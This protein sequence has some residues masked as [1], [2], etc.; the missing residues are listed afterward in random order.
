MAKELR[1]P[2]RELRNPQN[3]SSRIEEEFRRAGLD[4]HR[5]EIDSMEDDHDREERVIQA[6][7]RKVMVGFGRAS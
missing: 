3:C 4:V 2:H 6:R 7:T 1:I 5:D